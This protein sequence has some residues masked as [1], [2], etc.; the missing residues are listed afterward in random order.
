MYHALPGRFPEYAISDRPQYSA[1]SLRREMPVG[2]VLIIEHTGLTPIFGRSQGDMIECCVPCR[3]QKPIRTCSLCLAGDRSAYAPGQN[4]IARVQWWE[5]LIFSTK[6]HRSTVNL[7]FDLDGTLTDPKR[8]IVGCMRYA[9]ERLDRD[10]DSFSNLERFIGPPLLDS[11]YHLLGNE[12]EAQIALTLYRERFSTVGL[13]ENKVYEG[14]ENSLSELAANGCRMLVATSKPR[15]FAARIIHHFNLDAYFE[16]VYGSELDG[17]RADKADLIAYILSQEKL[18]VADTRMI[19][20]R[21]HD[22]NGAT[23][24]GVRSIG[25]LWGYGSHDEL[26]AA[27]ADVLCDSPSALLECIS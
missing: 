27:G 14:I 17:Q 4:H 3:C 10:P 6:R 23:K 16:F 5:T 13:Y 12:K 11:F 1:I 25:V 7:L 18:D 15:V 8:G 24:N 21:L 19:G 26:S 2:S 22:I 9:L 20:D